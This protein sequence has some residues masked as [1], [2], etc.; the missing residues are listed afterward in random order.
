MAVTVTVW[1]TFQL[2]LVNVKLVGAVV[3]SVPV[4]VTVTSL[5]G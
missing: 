5:A 1:A 4:S 3:T 2:A